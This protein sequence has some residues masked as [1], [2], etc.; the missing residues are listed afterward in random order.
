LLKNKVFPARQL[1]RGVH[2]QDLHLSW[3][4]PLGVELGEVRAGDP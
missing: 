4:S 2:H 1:I 3:N